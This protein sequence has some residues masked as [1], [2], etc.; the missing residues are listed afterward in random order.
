MGKIVS[1][2]VPCFNHGHYLDQTLNSIITQ[3]FQDWE[4]IIVNDGSTDNTKEIAN[5]WCETDNRF[6]YIKKQNGGLSS[7]RNAGIK[8]SE[9][10]FILP[11]DADDIIHRDYL[12]KLLP[13]LIKDESLAIVSCYSKFFEKKIDN[14]VHESK[15]KGSSIK[16]ILFENSIIATSLFRKS[17]W[18]EVGGYDEQMKNGFEDWE[19]WVAITKLGHHFKIVEDFLFYYRRTK[20]SMLSDTLKNYRIKNLEYVINKHKEIYREKFENTISYMFYL[21]NLY[22]DSETKYKYSKEYKLGKILCDPL[23]FFYK[24]FKVGDKSS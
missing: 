20:E 4:C 21:V 11:V 9:G 6:K 2:I 13:I 1:I 8:I 22:R 19:F 17:C 16:D 5:K 12:K 10:E 23:I 14:I 7:A 15:P 18:E 3:T 24:L